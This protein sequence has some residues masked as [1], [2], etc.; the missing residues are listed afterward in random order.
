MKQEVDENLGSAGLSLDR[1]P[2]DSELLRHR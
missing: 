1:R 2:L